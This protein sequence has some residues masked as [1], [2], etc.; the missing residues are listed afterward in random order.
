MIVIASCTT[1]DEKRVDDTFKEETDALKRLGDSAESKLGRFGD[2]AKKKVNILSDSAEN[3][4]TR[5][6]DSMQRR[7]NEKVDKMRDDTIDSA[8]ERL[9]RKTTEL[10]KRK[11]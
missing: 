6:K 9:K 1:Q 8:A 3:R 4:I 7:L 10:F 11:A 2:S 5:Y